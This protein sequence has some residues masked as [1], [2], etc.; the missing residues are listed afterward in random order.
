MEIPVEQERIDDSDQENDK[1][2]IAP[3]EEKVRG[4]QPSKK[5]R[6]GTKKSDLDTSKSSMSIEDAVKSDAETAKAESEGTKSASSAVEAAPIPDKSSVES[7][8]EMLKAAPRV[9]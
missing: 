9:R 3:A 1:K 7:I 5:G 6:R 4:R 2:T 8:S